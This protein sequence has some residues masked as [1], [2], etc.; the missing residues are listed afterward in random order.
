MSV[1]STNGFK[2][3][4]KLWPFL[5][6]YK[7]VLV[8][9][10]L[11]LAV[12][13]GTTLTMGKSIQLLIDQGFIGESLDQLNQTLGWMFA[14]VV[15]IAGGTFARFYLVTWLGERVTAD[16]RQAIFSKIITLHPSYFE[17]NRSGEIMSRLTT[18][19]TLLQSIIGS[20]LSFALRSFVM[21]LGGLVMLF[22]T[23]IKLTL[24]VLAVVPL[25]LL[26]I[27]IFGRR[28]RK[29][30]RK[31]Q[32]SIADVGTYAGEIIQQI[33]TVQSYRH[34]ALE[35]IA[36]SNEVEKAF[37]VAKQRIL[38]RSSLISIVILF[39][40]TAIGA[41]LWVGGYDVMNGNMT[42]GELA[43]FVFYALLVASGVA[44]VSEVLGEVQRAAGATERLI[45]LMD[46]ESLI[47]SPEQPN[48]LSAQHDVHLALSNVTFKYP[49]R[50]DT[51]ALLNVNLQINT[52]ESV[53]IVGPSGAGKSTLFELLLRFYD[54]Q[55][56][57]V[58]LNGT[59]LR[60]LSL[61]D[62]R[63]QIALVPQQPTLFSSDVW[64]N[65]RY[66]NPTAT[67][68]QVRAAAKAAY[69]LDFIEKLPQGF[70]SY[71]GENGVRL[72]G[73]QKQRIVIARAILSDTNILLLDEATSALDGESEF[74]VQQ[75]LETAM[76]NR[77]TL[78]IA[79]R[80]STVKNADRLIVMDQGEIVAV[81][82]HSDLLKTSIL[83]QNLAK[84]Q[85][86]ESVF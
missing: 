45:E 53:A 86:S 27:I 51:A 28:V 84:R 75:A 72:S 59:D 65:I 56:G 41:M 42:G 38:Q 23:N 12:T 60:T 77:T 73:G 29:L 34:E 14:A 81:G 33:K 80:L 82:T 6:P 83:Y 43:A 30:S 55:E 62:A 31:S 39:S 17:E 10:L 13:A 37:G 68:E 61:D 67:D 66:G 57:Q 70:N 74:N 24:I 47:R 15:L 5:R 48:P 32:D 1:S 7:W 85:F 20:S 44:S 19:T 25:V 54:P 3:L 2:T 40:F 35:N 46:E 69:A 8:G 26:P 16:L 79:H 78:I 76:E 49:S 50:P 21:M 22:I 36:F 71:L 63:G 64:H 58:L 52:G 9:A 11:S 4:Q 18:D